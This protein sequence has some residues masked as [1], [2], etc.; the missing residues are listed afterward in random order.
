MIYPQYFTYILFNINSHNYRTYLQA[1]QI[2]SKWPFIIVCLFTLLGCQKKCNHG[3]K[4]LDNDCFHNTHYCDN[5][6][7]LASYKDSKADDSFQ[8]FSHSDQD[9]DQVN[10]DLKVEKNYTIL[11]DAIWKHNAALVT[12]NIAALKEKDPAL[13][14]QVLNYEDP[15]LQNTPF[16]LAIANMPLEIIKTMAENGA[17]L[18]KH[19]LIHA[20]TAAIRRPENNFECLKF[21]IN[22]PN[23]APAFDVVDVILQGCN[24][25]NFTKLTSKDI[26]DALQALL[27]IDSASLSGTINLD[28][29]DE[30]GNTLLHHV[31]MSNDEI[32]ARMLLAKGANPDIANFK[33]E[34]PL[35]IFLSNNVTGITFL[36]CLLEKGASQEIPKVLEKR[37]KDTL[38]EQEKKFQENNNELLRKEI[39]LM[40]QKLKKLNI[41][42]DVTSQ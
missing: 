31:L 27:E 26:G 11:N 13:L 9:Q 33:G 7:D 41:S 5:P 12:T 28:K 25:S 42:T 16:S 4:K 29:V 21:I 22:N 24:K 38:K 10:K 1:L 8:N 36:N 3:L 37:L 17:Q 20:I 30:Q 18:S 19:T 35:H 34:K 32:T 23:L 6:Q 15:V 39:I 14:K 40:K 2:S